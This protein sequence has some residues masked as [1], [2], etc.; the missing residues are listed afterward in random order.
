MSLL[1]FYR[2]KLWSTFQHQ[3]RKLL[4]SKFLNWTQSPR[5]ISRWRSNRCIPIDQNTRKPIWSLSLLYQKA[6]KQMHRSLLVCL[7]RPFPSWMILRFAA[8]LRRIN[9]WKTTNADTTVL[10][11][12]LF[13][14]TWPSHTHAIATFKFH[15]PFYVRS[16]K[17]QT[18]CLQ[19][20]K[21][22][23]CTRWCWKWPTITTGR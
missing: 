13:W 10:S 12:E 17:I 6:V 23:L 19:T 4:G 20:S 22:R 3:T 9:T 8:S 11:R 16:I 7:R 21:T 15:W 14:I 2:P 18:I 5:T 1:P